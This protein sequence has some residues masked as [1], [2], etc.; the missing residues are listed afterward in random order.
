MSGILFNRFI[1]HSELNYILFINKTGLYIIIQFWGYN[2]ITHIREKNVKQ[3][4]Y[5]KKELIIDFYKY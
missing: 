2:L 4:Q 5:K 3:R 1:C